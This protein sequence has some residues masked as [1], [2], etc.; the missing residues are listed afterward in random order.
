MIYYVKEIF[1]NDKF[2]NIILQQQNG[3][4]PLVC[5][6]MFVFFVVLFL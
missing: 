2:Y 4:C 6:C 5:I 3:S 1:Y